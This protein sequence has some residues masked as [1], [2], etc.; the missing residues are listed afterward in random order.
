V[1]FDGGEILESRPSRELFA[2]PEHPR[3]K[4]FLENML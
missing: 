1:F 3:T 2:S 4:A